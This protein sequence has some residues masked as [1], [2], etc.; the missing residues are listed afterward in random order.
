M[1]LMNLG[2]IAARCCAIAAGIEVLRARLAQACLLGLDLVWMFDPLSDYEFT[3]CLGN[4]FRNVFGEYCRITMRAK[5]GH[6]LAAPD[7]IHHF[8]CAASNLE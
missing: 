8:R 4:A 3:A 6:V 7:F 1:A 2:A 5:R